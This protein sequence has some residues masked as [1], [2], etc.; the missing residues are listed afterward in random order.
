MLIFLQGNG[1]L[2][3]IGGGDIQDQGISPEA[4][5]L[6]NVHSIAAAEG[7]LLEEGDPVFF[8]GHCYGEKFRFV[9]HPH[10]IGGTASHLLQQPH[11]GLQEPLAG[12]RLLCRAFQHKFPAQPHAVGG[13][14]VGQHLLRGAEAVCSVQCYLRDHGGAV[15]ARIFQVGG[16]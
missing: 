3:G 7:G 6:L 5:A 2:P 12:F 11:T 8:P 14:P 9:G 4:E 15:K 10:I 13:P 16:V 1:L